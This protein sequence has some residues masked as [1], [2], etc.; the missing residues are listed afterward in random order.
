PHSHLAPMHWETHTDQEIA[1]QA[2]HETQIA[3]LAER[4]ATQLSAGELQRVFI[5]TALAQQSSILLLDEPTS[6][7]D[8]RQATRLSSLLDRLH[9]RGVTVLCASHDL[10]LLRRHAT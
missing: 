5:A 2:M 8:L 7:L 10:P 3:H 9:R 4:P 6:F 1:T